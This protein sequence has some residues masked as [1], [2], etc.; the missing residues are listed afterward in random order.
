[1]PVIEIRSRAT[2]AQ[3]VDNIA[4]DLAGVL[5]FA[6]VS[7]RPSAAPRAQEDHN[8]VSWLVLEG[9]ALLFEWCEPLSV[10]GHGGTVVEFLAWGILAMEAMVN[11]STVK[12][13]QS[14]NFV[15]FYFF[16]KSH[17]VF[18]GLTRAMYDRGST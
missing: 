14:L 4:R 18:S 11:L 5:V 2:R 7:D 10:L 16:S 8:F 9:S 17:F 6:D 3:P 1:M 15:S 12:V 13:R